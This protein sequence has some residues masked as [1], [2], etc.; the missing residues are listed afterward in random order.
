VKQLIRKSV[1]TNTGQVVLNQ[2]YSFSNPVTVFTFHTAYQNQDISNEEKVS[3]YHINTW[4]YEADR[5]QSLI[6][7]HKMN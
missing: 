2:S 7:Q 4:M 5:Q 6:M 3:L 1:R